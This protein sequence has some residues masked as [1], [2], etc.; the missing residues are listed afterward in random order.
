MMQVR[1]TDRPTTDRPTNDKATERQSDRATEQQTDRSID[2]CA[3]A[4]DVH[5][6]PAIAECD[7]SKVIQLQNA[8]SDTDIQTMPCIAF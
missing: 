6:A 3:A 8:S 2:Q 4:S 1:Q 7:S 5:P